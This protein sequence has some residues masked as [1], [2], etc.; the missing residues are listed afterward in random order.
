MFVFE[1]RDIQLKEYNFDEILFFQYI[2]HEHKEYLRKGSFFDVTPLVTKYQFM[3]ET[4]S[5]T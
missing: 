3:D 1:F 4:D 5:T 2:F